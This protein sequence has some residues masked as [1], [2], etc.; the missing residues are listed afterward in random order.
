MI[1][2]G[3]NPM[4]EEF[5]AYNRRRWGG[6]GW[7]HDLRAKGR[8]DGAGANFENW[9]WW[10]N[11]Y[12]AHQLVRF[13]EG[14]GIDTSTSNKVLFEAI[15][16]EGENVSLI[17]TL[18]RIAADKLSLPSEEVRT[19]LESDEGGAEIENDINNGRRKYSISGVPFF[20]IGSEGS[21]QLPYAMSGAQ[22][23][24]TF[25]RTFATVL[26]EKDE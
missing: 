23:S 2:P 7:T 6:S 1:D 4:G 22:S 17:D 11:T 5:E 13:A 24:N 16:E 9:K 21:G 15:Y 26:E 3:T 20:I 10:P 19:Y 14:K 8:K 25:L 12:K 18:V